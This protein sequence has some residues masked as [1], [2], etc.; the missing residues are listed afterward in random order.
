MLLLSAVLSLNTC[1]QELEWRAAEWASAMWK[2]CAAASSAVRTN[3][4]DL[5]KTFKKAGRALR[6]VPQRRRLARFRGRSVSLRVPL[7]W[8]SQ[9]TISPGVAPALVHF[10]R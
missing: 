6:P 10:C 4:A 8:H 2:A 5:A 7:G 1:R 3:T 9:A